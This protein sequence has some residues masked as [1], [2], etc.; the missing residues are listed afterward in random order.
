MRAGTIFVLCLAA[1]FGIFVTYMAILSRRS[2]KDESRQPET[3]RIGEPPH[4]GSNGK[5][6]ARHD[7][8]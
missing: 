8:R 7:R 2:G 6:K 4:G 3:A 1:A 5:R